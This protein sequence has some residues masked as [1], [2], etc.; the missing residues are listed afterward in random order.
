MHW[1]RYEIEF[2]YPGVCLEGLTE[3]AKNLDKDM[4]SPSPDF[5]PEPEHKGGV[6]ITGHRR[7]VLSR[8]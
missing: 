8:T 6:L 4:L 1:K 7:S 5:N 2:Y 3:K